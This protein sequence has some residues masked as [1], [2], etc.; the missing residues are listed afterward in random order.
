MWLLLCEKMQ[1][2]NSMSFANSCTISELIVC[3]KIVVKYF[4]FWSYAWLIVQKPETALFSR[5]S[6]RKE[7][8]QQHHDNNAEASVVPYNNMRT[9]LQIFH[10]HA[11]LVGWEETHWRHKVEC[12]KFD[13]VDLFYFCCSMKI[14]DVQATSP[15][16]VTVNGYNFNHNAIALESKRG[17]WTYAAYGSRCVE[18]IRAAW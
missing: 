15:N 9:D 10:M 16:R 4:I 11:I 8:W 3:E 13:E 7:P 18:R 1:S 2:L 17:N 12:G 5:F 14:N 6:E